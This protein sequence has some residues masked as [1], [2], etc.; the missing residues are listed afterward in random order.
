MIYYFWTI[1]KKKQHKEK[2]KT[3]FYQMPIRELAYQPVIIISV[4]IMPVSDTPKPVFHQTS[5]IIY[6][7]KIIFQTSTAK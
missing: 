6:I 5:L 2:Q 7:F 4:R 3:E 1:E